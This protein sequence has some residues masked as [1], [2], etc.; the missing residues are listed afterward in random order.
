MLLSAA[1]SRWPAS[2]QRNWNREVALGGD[3]AGRNEGTED[4]ALGGACHM[5]GEHGREVGCGRA[6]YEGDLDGGGGR[7]NRWERAARRVQKRAGR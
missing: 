2:W 6:N 3:Y 1:R 5:G 7:D 4:V